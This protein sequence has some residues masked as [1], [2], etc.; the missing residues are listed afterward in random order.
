MATIFIIDTP[1]HNYHITSANAVASTELTS[2]VKITFGCKDMKDEGKIKSFVSLIGGL[3]ANIKLDLIYDINHTH[4]NPT[5]D[6]NTGT[7]QYKT[8]HGIKYFAT[9]Q[10]I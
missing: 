10:S 8:F 7:L 5:F 1:K 2:G 9:L 6:D 4:F 3:D